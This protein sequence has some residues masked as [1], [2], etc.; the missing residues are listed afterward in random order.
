MR[1]SCINTESHDTAEDEENGASH[2][3]DM[4]LPLRVNRVRQPMN[5]RTKKKWEGEKRDETLKKKED[6]GLNFSLPSPRMPPVNQ[7]RIVI[8]KY[9]VVLNSRSILLYVFSKHNIH[10]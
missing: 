8:K 2:C 10:T 3:H 1:E 6:R 4:I 7:Q 9:S 5:E